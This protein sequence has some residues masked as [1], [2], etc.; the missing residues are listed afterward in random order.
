MAAEPKTLL[1][2]AGAN[3][4]PPPL[5][6]ATVVVIDAQREYIDGKLPFTRSSRRSPRS[7]SC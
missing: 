7:A 2:M 6:E 1:E 3:P 5:S 4:A